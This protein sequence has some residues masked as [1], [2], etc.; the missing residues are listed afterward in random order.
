MFARASPDQVGL[1]QV[2]K[3]AGISHA[4]ITH[5][6]GTYAGL[7]S[8]TLIRRV[9]RMR[10]RIL[11]AMRE[12]GSL[13]RAGELI[14]MLFDALEDPVHLRLLKWQVANGAGT[15]A[16]ALEDRG[17]SLVAKQIAAALDPHLD[18]SG[19]KVLETIEFGLVS[20]VASAFGYAMMKAQLAAAI[21]QPAEAQLSQR[22]QATIV[23]MLRTYL[24]A[25]LGLE[26]PM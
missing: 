13:S 7:V 8:A 20:V 22:L 5:Y 25:Q 10:E 21:G 19:P 9:R 18:H 14:A 12:V 1:K 17:V 11:A 23:E 3:A 26:L 16:L 6:F 2:A 24:R 4:L 15:G